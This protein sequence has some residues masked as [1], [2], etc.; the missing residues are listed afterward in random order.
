MANV[1]AWIEFERTLVGNG[2]VVQG[3]VAVQNLTSLPVS[4]SRIDLNSSPSAAPVTATDPY[5]GAGGGPAGVGVSAIPYIVNAAATLRFPFQALAHAGSM[6]E[7][8]ATISGFATLSDGTIVVIAPGTI[9]AMPAVVDQGNGLPPQPPFTQT[10]GSALFG[11]GDNS[12][13]ATSVVDE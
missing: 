1:N 8:S 13:I 5:F 4:I 9:T 12:N 7:G 11:S 10:T 2:S 6:V 3:Q